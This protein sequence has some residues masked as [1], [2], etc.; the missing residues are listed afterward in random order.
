M[1]LNALVVVKGGGDLATGAAYRLFQ[2][3]FQVLVT[4]I[5]QPTTVRRSVAFA[6]AVYA[7]ETVVDGVTARLATSP[8]RDFVP[9]LV[10]P[11]ASSIRK[12]SPNVV[13]DGIMAK[14]N[15]GTAIAHAP[16][17]V[18][19]G[20]G[21]EAGVDCHAVVETNRG[22]DLG[23]VIL[24]GRTSANTGVPGDI[25]GETERRI[26]RAPAAGTIRVC[27]QIGDVLTAG[28]VVAEVDGQPVVAQIDGVLRG[29]LHEG[30]PVRPGMKLGDVDPR[31]EVA[32]CFSISDKS[33]AVGGGVLEAVMRLLG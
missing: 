24:N 22:H 8:A 7:G 33:L 27:R 1:R 25:G 30:L 26:L 12:L 16:I 10:D 4:E 14:T 19:L 3:G 9:V 6:E 20:P 13:V 17:V 18:A 31:A 15:T 5:P 11:T 23:R 29:L 28:D 32:H 21:F 2:A